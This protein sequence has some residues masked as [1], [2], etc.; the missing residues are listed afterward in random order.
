M[1]T[2]K[3]LL[4]IFLL[5]CGALAA[6]AAPLQVTV[7]P[8][9]AGTL[10]LSQSGSEQ[11]TLT[12]TPSDGY[13]F[14]GFSGW[15]GSADGTDNNLS[16]VLTANFTP[17]Q[18]DST[19]PGTLAVTP[20]VLAASG[21]VGGPFSPAALSYTLRNL[22]STTIQWGA[23]ATAPWLALSASGGSLAPGVTTTITVALNSPESLGAGYYAD[24]ISFNNLT[25]GR[26]NGLRPA[27][28]IVTER[29]EDI[30]IV[31]SGDSFAAVLTV[32]PGANVLWSWA[33]GTTSNSATASKSFGSQAVR[34]NRLSVTPWS[35]LKRF[36]IGYDADDG[37]D[38][39]IERVPAQPVLAVSGLEHV[40]PYLQKWLS[41]RAQLTSL[42]FDNFVNLDTIECFQNSSLVQVSLHN[43][44]RLS[45]ACF[46]DC[47]LAALDL[48][49]S[50]AL[51]DLR[52]ANNRYSLVD[53]G[54]IG[55]RTWHICTHDNQLSGNLP[56]MSQFPQL[57]ELLIWNDNQRGALVTASS[58]LASVI[59]SGNHYTSADFS[60]GFLTGNGYLDLSDNQLTSLVLNGCSGLIGIS[61]ANNN[62]QS[63]AVDAVL[64]TLDSLGRF[65]GYLDLRGNYPPSAAGLAHAQNLLQRKWTLNLASQDPALPAAPSIAFAT[66]NDAVAME[67]R[68]TGNPTLTWHWSD[69][70]TETGLV[71]SHS[72]ADAEHRT[73]YLTVDPPSALTYFGSQFG[74]VQQGISALSGMAGFPNLGFLYLYKEG[75]ADLS[76]AGCPSLGELHLAGNPVSAAVVGKWFLDLDASGVTGGTIYIPAAA[77]PGY[78]AACASLT[79]KGWKIIPL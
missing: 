26:G 8:S 70:T 78:T 7:S 1:K 32:D 23:A 64:Q 75:L 37:G 21:A 61:A 5:L 42:N 10:S 27:N 66:E 4:A 14:N 31:T 54:A 25:N 20:G 49:E 22:G 74:V 24:T 30:S 9:G 33:D 68:V 35:A 12:A 3:I 45:R 51:S 2:I 59:A 76:L 38:Q 6:P 29:P 60:N 17:L 28:L 69:G 18:V 48:S 19:I 56:P 71:V 46:E 34:V 43:T 57:Q 44:P 77:N 65:T 40:A 39:A 53:F 52:G 63:D 47:Q 58:Q 62:L 72:F 41:S 55:A 73:H 16:L 67:V 15:S 50:P 36:N 13:L 11:V 79:Q